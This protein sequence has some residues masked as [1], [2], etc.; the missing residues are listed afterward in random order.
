MSHNKFLSDPYLY[1]WLRLSFCF[2]LFAVVSLYGQTAEIVAPGDED[3]WKIY[4]EKEDTLEEVLVES[5]SPAQRLKQVQIGAEVVSM[6]ELQKMPSLMGEKDVFKSLQL[7]PGVKA[8]SDGSSGYQVRGGT[9]AQNLVLLDN[10]TVYNAGHLLGVFSAFNASTLNNATLYK[11]MIPATYGGATSS[12]FDVSTRIGDMRQMHAEASVGLLSA[13]AFVEAP[14]VADK[15]SFFI[16]ARRSYLDLF[17]KA[18][19]EYK[20]NTLHFYDLNARFNFRLAQRDMLSVSAYS[21][22][23]NLGLEDIIAM[24]WGN[25][26]ATANWN[27]RFNSSLHNNLSLLFSRYVSDVGISIANVNY[28]M[29]GTIQHFTLR[30]A[31]QWSPNER[32]TLKFGAQASLIDLTSAEWTI[33]QL[34]EKERRKS[35][36]AALWLSEEWDPTQRWQLMGGIRLALFGVLGGSP[37]YVLDTNGDILQTLRYSSTDMFKSYLSLEPRISAKFNI[38][39][40]HNVKLG[41]TRTS[42]NIHAVR[43]SS[44]SMPF[45]RYTMTSNILKPSTARQVSLGY[46]GVSP[47]ETW[48]L[49]IEGYYKQVENIYDY[50]DGKSFSSEIEMERLLLGGKG[51]AYGAE[52]CVRRNH[53]RLTG[54]IA[55]TLSWSE[56]KIDGINNNDW[57]TAANDR[58]HDVTIVAM[59]NLTRRWSLSSVWTFQSGQALTAPSAKYE[60]DGETR[61]FYNERNGYR[62]PDYHRLDLSATWTKR[63]KRFCHELA[64]G[65]Y[66]AY[67]HY[68]P[69][70]I[71]F[72]DDVNAPSG[73]KTKMY[74][75]FAIIPS[76][77]YT[78]KF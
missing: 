5:K 18:F 13:K 41:Y 30:D 52:L 27:H 29:K 46:I 3:K 48:E 25:L 20:E 1:M 10:A 28:A 36:D 31:S 35:V 7:M 60:I 50:K 15:S 6:A 69:Y 21:G 23:D 78:I 8:E 55:Y 34:H 17:L 53:G 2:I 65:V 72:E 57:Y 11:G 67:C 70:M 22:R 40:H 14:I 76:V 58:R 38:S 59:Y 54:W 49:S 4:D 32:H 26:T 62:A 73:T 63:K 42:Q 68:N 39:E 56:N 43:M 24:K 66:N 77:N 51:R 74:S 9:T 19:P 45:D 33:L 37:Y 44:S 61:Y 71:L 16:G 12:V 47:S 64:F 75:L